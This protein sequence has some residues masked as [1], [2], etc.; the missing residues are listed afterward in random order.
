MTW[1]LPHFKEGQI[2]IG[3]RQV[4]MDCRHISLRDRKNMIWFENEQ[5]IFFVR[6]ISRFFFDSLDFKL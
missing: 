1:N 5:K 6:K 4:N 3:A 2:K